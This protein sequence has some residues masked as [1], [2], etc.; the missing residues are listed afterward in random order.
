MTDGGWCRW[1]SSRMISSV[2]P[3]S[4]AATPMLLMRA[5]SLTPSMLIV[6]V[7]TTRIAPSSSAFCAPPLVRYVPASAELPRNC[8]LVVIWG[9]TTCQSTA[10]AAIVTIAPTM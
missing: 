3:T 6:V 10:T 7:I 1:N 5:I 2:E 8:N 4:S 9:S